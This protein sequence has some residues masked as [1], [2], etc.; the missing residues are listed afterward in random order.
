MKPCFKKNK[1]SFI[2][3]F[4]IFIATIHPIQLIDSQ[5]NKTIEILIS[6]DNFIYEQ[7]LLGI[8]SSLATSYNI[9]YLSQLE[10][11]QLE[12]NSY[13]LNLELT[14][15]P[16][17]III[18]NQALEL[19][20]TKLNKI[21]IVFSM[22][23]SPRQYLEAYPRICGVSMDIP[24]KN[25][26]S[27]A[28]EINPNI[29]RAVSFYS[30]EAGEYLA[31]EGYY[32]DIDNQIIYNAV[33]VS[34]DLE[35]LNKLKSIANSID[36][37]I[38]INDPIYNPNNF[39]TLVE[40]SRK[41]NFI[42]AT[43]FPILVKSGASFSISPDY[44]SIG[45]NTAEIANKIM[46]NPNDCNLSNVKISDLFVFSINPESFS[47]PLPQ[48]ILER[49]RLSDII[50]VGINF[51]NEEKY[52]AALTIFNDVLK[53]DPKNKQAINYR[54][55]AKEKLTGSKTRELM[56]LAED[57][58]KKRNYQKAIQ[59]YQKVLQI[60]PDLK[61]AQEGLKKSKEAE[62]ERERVLASQLFQSGKRYEAIRLL[63]TSLRKFP[64]PKSQTDLN[65]YRVK[66]KPEIDS[67][68]EKGIQEYDSR[69]YDNSIEIFENILLVDPNDKKAQEYLR[70]SLKKKEALVQLNQKI[71]PSFIIPTEN[72]ESD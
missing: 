27:T 23:Q 57:A 49:A 32:F 50:E 24:M 12:F 65:T 19:A 1:S 63:L 67:Y 2:N 18:G 35:F 25:Y 10:A 68:F 17:V 9:T 15:T 45:V 54:A 11:S 42:V 46:D 6:S 40:E 21:P 36:L 41:N 14:R 31:K 58:F 71:P 3:F 13:F 64:N 53:K 70:L 4:F 28:R 61:L 5:E 8:E 72:K 56:A 66:M 16:L 55:I 62:S 47:T 22:V 29:K 20:I 48:E 26:F 34:N 51:L 39:Q 7:A 69:E 52:K 60:N 59:E 38:M 33:K 43:N 37:F 30:I 44:T